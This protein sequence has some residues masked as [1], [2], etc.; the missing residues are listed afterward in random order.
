M[1]DYFS[2]WVEAQAF[3]KV[4]EKEVI[5]F[6]WDHIM[7]QFGIPTKIVCNNGK[8][9]IGSKVSKFFEDH[10][11]KK[12]LSPPHYP[13]GNG[14]AKSTNKT[15]LQNLKKRLTDSNGKWKEICPSPVG[16]LKVFNE[17][18][19]KRATLDLKTGSK[20]ESVII[21]IKSTVSESSLVRPRI[22][23]SITLGFRS[24][25][26]ENFM[27]QKLAMAQGLRVPALRSRPPS[28]LYPAR[29]GELGGF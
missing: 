23:G 12:I 24:L 26:R 20:L 9:F 7:C 4:R 14:Q 29:L 11:I 3:V 19:V 18:T 2:K 28:K 1:A 5:D 10:K 16:I 22:L 17:A 8:Q 25:A 27:R 6:I 15:I 13:S 21:G